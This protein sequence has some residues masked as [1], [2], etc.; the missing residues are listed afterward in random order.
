MGIETNTAQGIKT[1]FKVFTDA[2]DYT[3]YYRCAGIDDEPTLDEEKIAYPH[4]LI[5][6]APNWPTHHKSTF[7]DVP[8][9][10]RWATHGKKDPKEAILYAIYEGCRAILDADPDGI[11]VSGMSVIG[12]IIDQGGESDVEDHEQYIEM[13]ITVKLCGA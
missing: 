4:I 8:V 2:L 5:T 12:I 1:A 6:A 3:V 7:R 11:T 13:P 10:L 9:V